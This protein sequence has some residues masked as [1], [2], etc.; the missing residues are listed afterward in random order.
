LYLIRYGVFYDDDLEILPGP[1]M[2]FYG[3][4]HSN[5][6]IYL[7]GPLSFYD[8]VTAHGNIYHRR[9]DDGSRPG[10]AKIA[11]ASGTL[12]SMLDRGRYIDSDDADWMAES[13]RRWQGN[14]ASA[15]H[16]TPALN[17]PIDPTSAPHDL[18]ER[19]LPVGDAAYRAETEREKFANKAALTIH[20]DAT[21]HLRATD[22]RGNDVTPAF[23]NASLTVSGYASGKPLYAKNADGTYP[24]TVRGSYDVTQADF[25]DQREGTPMAPVDIY[26]DELLQAFPALYNGTYSVDDGRGIVY[27]TRDDPDGA[28]TGVQP[29]VRVR[30][31]REIAA[32]FGLSI[33]SD[34]PVYVEGDYNTVNG[35]PAL[36]AGDAVTLLSKA[37]QDARSADANCSTRTAA[38]T[39][40]NTVIMTGNTVTTPGHYNGGLENV[41]RFLENWTSKTVAYRGS[42]IDLWESEIATSAWVYGGYYTAPNRDWGYDTRYLTQNPPGMTRVLG[43]EELLWTRS[44]WGAE[45]W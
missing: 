14:V 25:R 9:K 18:I 7:G 4:T 29:C 45:G 5:R 1:S 44:T 39:A 40:Y 38:N 10:E 2:W 12:V 23:S 33:V 30:N 17:P 6:D 31:G 11:D 41:L 36:V 42:I 34:L 16:G 21:G 32:P 37:W 13:V 35:K 27:V 22:T 20:V 3:R 26:V 19:P 24:M 43:I 8:R 15:V 28:G